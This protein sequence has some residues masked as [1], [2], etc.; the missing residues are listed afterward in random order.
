M[1][2]LVRA[3]INVNFLFEILLKVV[4]NVE[5]LRFFLLESL[6]NDFNKLSKDHKE[7]Q[8]VY[9]AKVDNSLEET[10]QKCNAYETVKLEETKIYL[11]NE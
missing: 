8:K 2:K 7:L 4:F 5:Y 6:R 11:E 3:N 9:E 10:I 1:P